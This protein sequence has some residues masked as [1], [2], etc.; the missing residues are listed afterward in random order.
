[1]P[2]TSDLNL[3]FMGTPDFAVPSLD[4]LVAAGYRPSA[5]VTVPDRRQGRG[6]QIQESPIKQAATRHGLPVLQPEKLDDSAFVDEL[7]TLAPEVIAVVA[8]QILPPEVYELASVGAF[9][10]HASLLP[11]YRGAAPINRAIMNG[12]IETGVTTFFLE[13]KV[14]TGDTILMRRVGIEPNETAGELHDRLAELGA[15]VV[16]ETVQHIEAG[17]VDTLEQDEARAS[18]APKIFKDDAR[19]DWTRTAQEVHNH[20]RGLAPYP[21]AW[22]EDGDTHLK[23]YKTCPAKGGGEPGEV[24]EAEGECLVVACGERAVEILEIQRQGKARMSAEEF[25]RGYTF[26]PGDR[27]G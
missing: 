4:A 20:V 10:L 19:I 7:K 9:N 11:Q 6:Q 1:M 14:D 27:L 25:L 22:T 23:I 2:D 16:V 17:T 15:S 5:V 18:W 24:I 12:E 13:R 3:I 21:A 8:F 26:Q